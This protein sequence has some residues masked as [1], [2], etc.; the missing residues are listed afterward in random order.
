MF[1]AAVFRAAIL[2]TFLCASLGVVSAQDDPNGQYVTIVSASLNNE[3]REIV[4]PIEP[5]VLRLFFTV[6]SQG[7]IKWE[8]IL[9]L[10]R[11]FVTDA[12]N[13]SV[14][15]ANGKRSVAIW[16]PRPGK[17]SVRLTGTG[18][19][20]LTVMSQSDIYACCLNV[21]GRQLQPL[22]RLQAA[23]GSRL[24]AN[25]YV[26]GSNLET[27]DFRL[28]NEQSEIIGPVKFRQSDLSNPYNF[29]LL[30]DVPAQPCRVL[31]RGR[32]QSGTSFQRIYPSLIVPAVTASATPETQPGNTA[33]PVTQ[34][35]QTGAVEGEYRVV[36]AQ[37]V[38]SADELLLSEKGNPVGI[39]LKYTMRFPVDG[40]Y[41][42]LPNLY[43]EKV[44]STFTGALSMRVIRSTVTPLPEGVQLPN[45]VLYG[46]RALYKRDVEYQ[47]TVDLVPNYASYNEQQK[48]FCL[49]TKG[50]LQGGLRERFEREVTG[51]GR[52]RYRLTISG[53]DYDGRQMNLTEKAYVPN[54]WYVGLQKEGAVECQ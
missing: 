2:V 49:Q 52:Q 46:G 51:E 10:G 20:T 44:T 8:V 23:R 15:D 33:T 12:P 40:N 25:A 21:V 13:V 7:G 36:R 19:F 5:T 34:S 31:V 42:P 53:T 16:D 54:G 48:K 50:F 9:P 29:T 43:P 32:E 22:E 30:I 41:T 1:A 6:Q 27:V 37:V 35:E 17:W 38:N 39:R 11:P 47:F 18:M 28:V 14:T 3:T 4:A 45:L 26:S 24:Q